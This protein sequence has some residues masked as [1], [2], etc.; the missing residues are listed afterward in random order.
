MSG[1]D[2]PTYFTTAVRPYAFW[3]FEW[4]VSAVHTPP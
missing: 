4:A 2:G 1:L 3:I